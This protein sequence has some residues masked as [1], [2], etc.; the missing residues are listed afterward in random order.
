[1][2]DFGSLLRQYREA[3]TDPDRP[4]QPLTQE[5]LGELLGY[6]GA[7]ISHWEH[8]RHP[9]DHSSLLRLIK[10]LFQ[11]SG[12][13]TVDQADHLLQVCNYRPLNAEEKA[14]LVTG[15]P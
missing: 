9:I 11:C 6:T 2:S 15:K 1:M 13:Q 8:C 4:G 12:L 5:R 7:M 14:G 10:I 3:C